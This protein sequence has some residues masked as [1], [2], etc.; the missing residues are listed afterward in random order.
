[1][2][3]GDFLEL[4]KKRRSIRRLKS[5][6]IPD[7]YVEKI[8]EAA[9]WAPS[10][11]NSQPWEYIV[12]KDKK[13]KDK[14][15]EFYGEHQKLAFR[16]E[17]TR[18]SAERMPRFNEMPKFPPSFSVAPVFILV[19]GDPR[20]KDAYPLS[21]VLDY[22]GSHFYSSLASSF[23]YMHL[24]ATTLGLGTRWVSATHS[25]SV[26]CFIKQLLGIPQEYEVYDMLVLGYVEKEPEQR[27]VRSMEDI[28]HYEGYDMKKYRTAEQVKDFIRDSRLSITDYK[29]KNI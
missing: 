4:V 13:L 3:Y 8:L 23:L 29:N 14:I 17:Q 28:V 22:A 26:E 12:I 25:P 5:D 15:V 10:G 27:Y 6:P 18:F 24:A 9:R 11:A 16:I 19:V 21:S 1:M 20:S 7:E 2:D